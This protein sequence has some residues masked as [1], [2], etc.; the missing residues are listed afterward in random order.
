MRPFLY[1]PHLYLL[2]ERY[3]V[4]VHKRQSAL[5]ISPLSAD[6]AVWYRVCMSADCTDH[7]TEF[8]IGVDWCIRNIICQDVEACRTLWGSKVCVC[9]SNQSALRICQ[10]PAHAQL[11]EEDL[12]YCLMSHPYVTF[13]LLQHQTSLCWDPRVRIV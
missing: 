11:R 7:H 10:V 2:T 6:R 3:C 8:Q 4:Q 13:P 1:V 12:K 5:L 9:V